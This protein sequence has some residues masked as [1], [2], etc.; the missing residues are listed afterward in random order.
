MGSSDGGVLKNT[1]I[2]IILACI[3]L[4]EVLGATRLAVSTNNTNRLLQPA[5]AQSGSALSPPTQPRPVE[6]TSPE[7]PVSSAPSGAELEIDKRDE[8]NGTSRTIGTNYSD[9]TNEEYGISLKYPSNADTQQGDQNS[10]DPVIDLIRV[11]IPNSDSLV[12]LWVYP[13]SSYN[14]LL[15][16]ADAAITSWNRVGVA[17]T[18]INASASMGGHPAYQFLINQSPESWIH[19]TLTLIG[20]TMYGVDYVTPKSSYKANLPVV[21]D[22]VRSIEITPR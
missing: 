7:A 11:G 1:V 15:E 8:G 4:A 20:N 12:Y 19:S 22:L 6:P 16:S 3:L 9:Y 17:A 2:P 13:N 10:S 5:W 14:S 18:V 21:E